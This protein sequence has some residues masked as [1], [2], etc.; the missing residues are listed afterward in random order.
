MHQ[1]PDPQVSPSFVLSAGP[2]LEANMLAH[3]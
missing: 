2:T 3:F 1:V